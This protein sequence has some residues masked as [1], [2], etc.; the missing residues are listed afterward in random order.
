MNMPM[1]KK[2]NESVI[3]LWFKLWRSYTSIMLKLQVNIDKG[4]MRPGV[5]LIKKQNGSKC[6]WTLFLSHLKLLI[7]HFVSEGKISSSLP[8][9]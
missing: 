4:H 1:E 8:C 2:N 6:Y 9:T 5:L 7:V 3:T